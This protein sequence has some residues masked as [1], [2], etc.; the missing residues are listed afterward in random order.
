MNGQTGDVSDIRAL[1]ENPADSVGALFVREPL[2]YAYRG[3]AYL[4]RE[5]RERFAD[6]PLPADGVG[7]RSLLRGEIQRFLGVPLP[8]DWELESGRPSALYVEA[9]DPGH[10]MSAGTVG[11]TWW[12]QTAIPILLDR[13]AARTGRGM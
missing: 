8:E 10:G 1:P 11:L 7:L 12:S 4:W 13:F 2:Q 3:D 6:S 5:L 9:L